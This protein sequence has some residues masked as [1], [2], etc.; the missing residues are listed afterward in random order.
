MARV[1]GAGPDARRELAAALERGRPVPL[2]ATPDADGVNFA[3]FSQHAE[4]VELCLFDA[5]GAQ[6]LAR[7]RLPARSGHVWHGYLP[8]ARPGCVYGFRAHGPYRPA[9][10]HRFNPN[11]LLLDPYARRTVGELAWCDDVLGYQAGHADRDLSFSTAD[12]WRS[13]PKACVAAPLAEPARERR[14][15]IAP[16][17]TVLYEL[18]V[19]GFTMRHPDV[20][21]ALRGTYAGLASEAATGHL[22]RLG[23]TTLSLLPVHWHVSER[24]LH[25]HGLRNY[26]GYNSLGY[27][28]PH[29]GYASSQNGAGPEAEFRSMVRALHQAGL[30]VVL[31]VVFNHTAESDELGPTLSLRG[32]DN[33]SYYRCRPGAARAYENFSGCGNTLNIA[34]P[35]VLQLVM[36]SLRYWVQAMGVD[37]FRFDLAPALA[38]GP[39]G[40]DANAALLQA[41]AQDP[42]LAG[43]KL[44]AEPWDCGPGGHQLGQFPVGWL[45]WNDRF[46]DAARGYWL[47]RDG[48]RDELA[49]RLTASAECFKAPGRPPTASVNFI[50]AHDGFTLTDL[51]Q[52]ERRHN[53]ANG[54]ANRDGAADNLSCNCGVEGPSGDTRVREQR[55][56]LQRALLAT[57]L[58]AQGTPMLTAGDELGRTQHGNNNAYCQDNEISWL[59][60]PGADPALA[61]FVSELIALRRALRPMDSGRWYADAHPAES[62][63]ALAWLRADGAPMAAED[64]HRRGEPALGCRV[65]GAERD[66]LLLFNASAQPIEFV[67]PHG[68]WQPRLVSA[69]EGGDV[70]A[71]GPDA[72]RFP[73]AAHA[74][75]V[76]QQAVAAGA[77]AGQCPDGRSPGRSR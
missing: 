13:V 39:H 72:R 46:R 43:V 8:G 70:A 54:E 31:D 26:W 19:R 3:V 9:D 15:Q 41:I 30:E 73:L 56:R 12:D 61:S 57:L 52:Y 48:R 44:I 34:H 7:H 10:G 47:M 29:P 65:L 21:A 20:P 74:V 28:C 68:S 25:A 16:E 6:A 50:T 59:A 64:W 18:H 2:G 4:A 49:R 33:L 60:W 23:V 37:G 38:R 11:K 5:H 58:L 77:V 35:N 14:P 76:L 22:R 62:R 66:V 55:E 36:D 32:L 69:R 40:F 75:A 17:D 45:E 67:L 24:R 53:E 71:A 63:C 51:V 1:T 42:V 27:F